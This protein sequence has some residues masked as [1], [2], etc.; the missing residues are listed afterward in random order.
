MECI[1]RTLGMLFVLTLTAVST[2]STIINDPLL[3]ETLKTSIRCWQEPDHALPCETV[4]NVVD[5]RLRV[6]SLNVDVI[7]LANR[8]SSMR[9][10][11]VA[12][13]DTFST[14]HDVINK[15]DDGTLSWLTVAEPSRQALASSR[16]EGERL[17]PPP[18]PF[19]GGV[20]WTAQLDDARTKIVSL[21][22][23]V[24]DE[25]EWY[26]QGARLIAHQLR[27]TKV[28][29]VGD[30]NDRNALVWFCKRLDGHLSSENVTHVHQGHNFFPSEHPLHGVAWHEGH[31]ARIHICHV[32]DYELT[33]VNFFFFGVSQE[34]EFATD[35]LS[36]VGGKSHLPGEVDT[37][38]VNAKAMLANVHER[39]RYFFPGMMKMMPQKY[40]VERTVITLSSVVWDV[41][42]QISGKYIRSKTPLTTE[43]MDGIL[44][45]FSTDWIERVSAVAATI[46]ETF[47]SIPGVSFYWRTHCRCPWGGPGGRNWPNFLA[48]NTSH[49][50][51]LQTMAEHNSNQDQ[52]LNNFELVD[53]RS[54]EAV[55]H[56]GV[57]EGDIHKSEYYSLFTALSNKIP[58]PT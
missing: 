5:A 51:M 10:K 58:C 26:H 8:P 54:V 36:M 1:K 7:G 31:K 55:F 52:R 37:L 49:A 40:A 22:Q 9:S 46:T 19:Y 45:Y 35:W 56:D 50:A 34:K 18:G 48:F 41:V 33:L 13:V 28:V 21:T 53:W 25:Q 2:N 29:M 30:S 44:N 38:D 32:D 12:W 4:M 57:C 15:S 16:K 20:R 11:S 23:D 17:H 39:I 6:P 24:L 3:L 43:E 42:P 47:G 27:N 14:C